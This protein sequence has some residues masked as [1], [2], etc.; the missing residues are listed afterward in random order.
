MGILYACMSYVVYCLGSWCPKRSEGGI[1][2]LGTGVTEGCESLCGCWELSP[3]PLDEQSEVLTGEP[4]LQTPD[5]RLCDYQAKAF[6][7]YSLS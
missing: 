3:C 1:G 7:M 4:S 2:Y 5:L 6:G